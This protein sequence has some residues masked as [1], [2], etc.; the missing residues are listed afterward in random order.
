MI[1]PHKTPAPS[2]HPPPTA[3]GLLE[4]TGGVNWLLVLKVFVG[5]AATL[6][7]VGATTAALFAAGVYAPNIQCER[8]VH[9]LANAHAAAAQ[10]AAVRC[11]A[12]NSTLAEVLAGGESDV[13]A[14]VLT[15]LCT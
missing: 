3:V 14:A 10:A 11:E 1:H 13:C 8:G 2:P 15:T 6:V 5:W 4:G 9:A 7:V 12:Q